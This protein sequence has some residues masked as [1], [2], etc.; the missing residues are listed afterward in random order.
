MLTVDSLGVRIGAAK[1]LDDVS[2]A[3]SPGRVTAILGPNGAGKSTLLACL[4]GLRAP[5]TG[6]VQLDGADIHALDP[7]ERARRVGLLPQGGALHWNIEVAALV[8]LGRIPRQGRASRL[9]DADRAAIDA[10][11]ARTDT[12]AFAH[13]LAG[14]L[15]GGERARVLLARVL[16]GEPDWVLADEPL[17]SLDLA[18]QFDLM[19]QLR[20]VAAGGTG[21]IVALHDLSL[22]LRFAD[23]ALLLDRGRLVA[24]GPVADVLTPNHI[25]AVFG[26]RMAP[27]PD[28]GL[29]ALGRFPS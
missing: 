15:S 29:V 2:A 11:L 22:A 6:I 17:A 20:G 4:A 10:A 9:S 27:Y 13:R 7:R 25:A 18:H 5:T 23:D 1:L 28:G 24:A 12:A 26:M 14:T 8:A 3:L 19:A 21:V 16:A